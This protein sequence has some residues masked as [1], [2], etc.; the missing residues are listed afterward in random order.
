MAGPVMA[1]VARCGPV[2]LGPV[3]LCV[4]G[5]AWCGLSRSVEAGLGMARRGRRG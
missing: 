3:R 4:A 5:A 2:R 1:G